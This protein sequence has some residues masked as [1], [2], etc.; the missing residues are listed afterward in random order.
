MR[1][2]SKKFF[3]KNQ[4]ENLYKYA[5]IGI[6]VLNAKGNVVDSNYYFK[7]V[8]G[9]TEADLSCKSITCLFSLEKEHQHLF[10][11]S[12]INKSQNSQK[13]DPFELV[14]IKKDGA[15][16]PVEISLS[17]HNIEGQS[18]VLIFVHDISLK[19]KDKIQIQK[20]YKELEK[21]IQNRTEELNKTLEVVSIIN[22]KLEVTLANQKAILDNASIM[23]FLMDENGIIQFFNPAAVKLTGYTENEIINKWSPIIFHDKEELEYCKQE[24]K[25]KYS[26]NI[27]DDWLVI[28][29][30]ADRNE[31]KEIECKY[32][33]K[34]NKIIDVLLTIT[35]I[36]DKRKKINGYL[37]AAVNISERKKLETN[38]L[39]ALDK[40]KKLGEMKSNFISIAS[41]EFRTPL[42]TILSS[43][44]LA[45]KYTLSREQRNREKHLQRIINATSNLSGILNDFLSVGKIDEGKISIHFTE[46]DLKDH[47][48]T[49]LNDMGSLLK[50]GQY[51][52]YNHI[53]LH[54]VY[55]DET[56]IRNILNNLLS[57]AIK[58]SPECSPITIRTELNEEF[59]R[60]EVT[61]KGIG[62]S[63]K[64]QEHLMDRFYRA[65]NAINISGTGLGLHIVSKYAERLN[66]TLS[67]ESQINQG[68]T[69]TVLFNKKTKTRENNF[70]N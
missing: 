8:F 61:D 40:E 5:S 41:H 4:L 43:A 51:F 57:N 3:V 28:K 16:F 70:T 14:G 63:K 11:S 20:L 19:V 36:Y 49:I 27:S 31:I 2:H 55:L 23:L 69:F 25:E 6:V 34:K 48:K 21:N 7:K 10:Y 38:L 12:T 50:E 18:C 47:T 22:E 42:S 66:G 53:G 60:I 39:D 44:Y 1:I 30:K 46:F 52:D 62:I 65:S 45:G 32:I 17:Y 59:I 24:L 58:F 37:G 15:M 56:L 26:I 29:T 13:R 67:F 64:D 54:K 33:S 68:S 35:P 9:Y